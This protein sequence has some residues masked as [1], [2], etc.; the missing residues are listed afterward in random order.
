MACTVTINSRRLRARRSRRGTLVAERE[1]PGGICDLL[2]DTGRRLLA[3]EETVAHGPPGGPGRANKGSPFSVTGG[4]YGRHRRRPTK[5]PGGV[6][7]GSPGW[8]SW[9]LD[10][11]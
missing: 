9:R 2:E 6:I 10:V 8:W 3:R 7:S 1:S 5:R 4:Q 11:R